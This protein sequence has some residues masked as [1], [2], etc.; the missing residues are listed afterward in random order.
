M[1]YIDHHQHHGGYPPNPPLQPIGPPP[2]SVLAFRSPPAVCRNCSAQFDP[3]FA[4]SGLCPRCT[5][6]LHPSQPQ[7]LAVSCPHPPST[8]NK[9]FSMSNMYHTIE[10]V[11][12]DQENAVE[13]N[14]RKVC[15]CRKSDSTMICG[16]CQTI[17]CSECLSEHI[18]DHMLYS[19]KT[20]SEDSPPQNCIVHKDVKVSL[21]C[22]S[23]LSILCSSCLVSDHT[24]HTIVSISEAY[25]RYRPSMEQ[26]CS[27]SEVEINLLD[28]SLVDAEKMCSSIGEKQSIAVETVR[29]L[30]Q[31]H[32]TELDKREKEVFVCVG[33]GGGESIVH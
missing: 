9:A 6:L 11:F 22:Q 25:A 14:L 27:K 28:L 26:L 32:R 13:S 18:Q 16:V 29:K 3:N 7:P 1:A 21:F 17:V 4:V 10:N 12:N 23:C 15:V 5:H 2:T 30:F 31:K 19:N 24:G 33:G 20:P 8:T